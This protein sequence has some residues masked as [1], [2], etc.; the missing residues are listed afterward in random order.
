MG[1]IVVDKNL[2]NVCFDLLFGIKLKTRPY[3]YALSTT[4]KLINV[5]IC[6]SLIKKAV[7]NLIIKLVQ[8]E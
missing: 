6:E 2:S 4:I 3:I 5:S 7:V 1:F 8:M